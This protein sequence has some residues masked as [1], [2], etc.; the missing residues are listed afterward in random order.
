MCGG[1][2]S[3]TAAAVVEA[4]ADLGRGWSD[5]A[6]VVSPRGYQD[7]LAAAPLAYALRMPIVLAEGAGSIDPAVVRTMA[8][9]GIERAYLVGGPLALGRPVV[10]QLESGGIDVLGEGEGPEYKGEPMRRLAGPTSVETS[11]AVAEFGIANGLSASTVGVAA[12]TAY[13]DALSGAALCGRNGGVLVL[14]ADEGSASVTEFVPQHAPEI[15]L[16]CVFGGSLVVSRATFEA[17]EG[18]TDN[19]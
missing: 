11:M 5:T 3:L 7:A 13:A 15:G 8:S 4:G 10:D 14:A 18:A 17:L 16:G 2:A 1:T 19:G 6:L 9:C 12:K